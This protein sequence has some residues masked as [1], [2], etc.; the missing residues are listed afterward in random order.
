[1]AV[2]N[3]TATQK[4]HKPKTNHNRMDSVE[5]R[6]QSIE[7]SISLI[8]KRLET[9]AKENGKITKENS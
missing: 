8:L 4:V 6:M 5:T 7:Q 2:Y 3:L 9:N 1:M